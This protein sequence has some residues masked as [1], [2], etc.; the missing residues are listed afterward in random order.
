MEIEVKW[1]RVVSALVLLVILLSSGCGT[2]PGIP[3]TYECT[4]PTSLS[5]LSSL[6]VFEKGDKLELRENGD[7]VVTSKRGE[8][9]LEGEWIEDDGVVEIVLYM[10]GGYTLN[11]AAALEGKKLVFED[12]SEWQKRR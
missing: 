9:T 1:W 4:R 8:Y 3:G 6:L 11:L 12:K 7:V 5:E 10:P 2:K